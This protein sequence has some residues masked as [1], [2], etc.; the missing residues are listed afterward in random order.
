MNALPHNSVFSL[1][2][3]GT[4]LVIVSQNTVTYRCF[5]GFYPHFF[6]CLCRHKVN[7][8]LGWKNQHKALKLNS[9][10]NLA[11]L[12]FNKNPLKRHQICI[13]DVVRV[14]VRAQL[15]T[16]KDIPVLFETFWLLLQLLQVTF[17]FRRFLCASETLLELLS[18]RNSTITDLEEF[19]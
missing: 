9:L 3:N 8:S 12:I 17:S 13:A 11:W 4:Q 6:L 2:D 5:E 15:F 7:S 18:A 10:H 1:S 14:I 19:R 16:L